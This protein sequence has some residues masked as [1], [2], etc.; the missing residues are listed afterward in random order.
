MQLFVKAND[1]VTAA[2]II[3]KRDQR[4]GA[5]MT[6]RSTG[7]LL[8]SLAASGEVELMVNLV[9]SLHSKRVLNQPAVVAE[10]LFKAASAK[11]DSAL[12]DK[13]SELCEKFVPQ[14][15]LIMLRHQYAAP[16]VAAVEVS[17][18]PVKEG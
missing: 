17:E 4:L 15:D 8:D 11:G 5:W 1:P 13:A 2:Q 3:V 6:K 14:T 9:S 12:Y 10:V 18:E 16:V 7:L